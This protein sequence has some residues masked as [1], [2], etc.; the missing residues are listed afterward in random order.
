MVFYKCPLVQAIITRGLSIAGNGLFKQTNLPFA[1]IPS[2]ITTF[3]QNVFYICQG[4]TKVILENGLV[5]I[6][7]SMFYAT[8]LKD[9]TV[10]STVTYIGLN[11]YLYTHIIVI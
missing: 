9:L 11:I 1:S 4:L 5:S 6:G 7:D 3:G 2:T 10:P 8:P